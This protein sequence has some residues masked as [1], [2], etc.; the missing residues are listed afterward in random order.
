MLTSSGH[1]Q[2]WDGH[3]EGDDDNYW[4]PTF[5]DNSEGVHPAEPAVRVGQE[6]RDADRRRVYA[7]MIAKSK[8]NVNAILE[9]VSSA[10]RALAIQDQVETYVK[11]LLGMLG[12]DA[13]PRSPA[14]PPQ[15][16]R[17][18]ERFTRQAPSK[19]GKRGKRGQPA[20]D[21]SKQPCE[22]QKHLTSVQADERFERAGFGSEERTC[23]YP[24]YRSPR[25]G[26]LRRRLC[27]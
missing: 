27:C 21:F 12:D 9:S 23:N 18:R 5:D 1:G 13:Q 3:N 25:V 10:E 16:G 2:D 17:P 11:V 6:S 7:N 24:A 8:E 15:E 20:N 4:G 19:T 26:E 22:T 14:R